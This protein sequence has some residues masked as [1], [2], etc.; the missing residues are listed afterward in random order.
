MGV[1]CAL[2][3]RNC[4]AM[5]EH[6]SPRPTS[7]GAL[8]VGLER[9]LARPRWRPASRVGIVIHGLLAA[10]PELALEGPERADA[11]AG[12]D[13]P[14]ELDPPRLSAAAAGTAASAGPG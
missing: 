6:L 12:R 4:A 2:L 14:D 13:P 3:C 1:E 10:D 7:V 11:P 5:A 9:E 8:L